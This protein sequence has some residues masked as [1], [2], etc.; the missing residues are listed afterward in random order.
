MGIMG[1]KRYHDGYDGEH[2]VSPQKNGRIKCEAFRKTKTAQRSQRK[3][4]IF[5]AINIFLVTRNP[6]Y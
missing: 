2:W 5:W 1:N 3:I 6:L 4:Y